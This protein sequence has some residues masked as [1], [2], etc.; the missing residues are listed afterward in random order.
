MRHLSPIA[1]AAV[2]AQETG[3]VFIVLLTISHPTLID[4]E[5]SAP[6]PLRFCSDAVQTVSRGNAYLPF[7]FMLALASE[8][9]QKPPEAILQIDN[10]DRSITAAI[11]NMGVVPCQILI[12][13]VTSDTPDAVEYSSGS[14][15]LRDVHYDAL[16][17]SGQLAFEQILNEP[18]PS[19]LVT[20]A[21]IPGVFLELMSHDPICHPRASAL[22]GARRVPDSTGAVATGAGTGIPHAPDKQTRGNDSQG[23]PPAWCARYVG[24]PFRSGGR[25]R[26]FGCDCYGLVWIVLREQF[27][28]AAP[29]YSGAYA[30]A[31]EAREIAALISG[32]TEARW[33]KDG[34]VS[35]R[36]Y[37]GAGAVVLFRIAGHP[38]HVGIVVSPDDGHGRGSE[39]SAR[40]ENWFLHI[41]RGTDSCLE[42]LDSPRWTNRIVGFYRYVG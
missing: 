9:P 2:Y 17:V 14:M 34:R 28:V 39:A 5:T 1:L 21:T 19:T 4:P 6:A 22:P 37:A 41:R 7:P 10:I 11:R 12:E 38:W 26:H 18:F 8:D 25:D 16:T 23:G 42:R 35:T 15:T 30:D 3:T 31:L 40:S 33:Q 24:I 32:E 13:L 20:P 27:G 29:S 36:P